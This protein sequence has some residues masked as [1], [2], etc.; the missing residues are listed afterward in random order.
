MYIPARGHNVHSPRKK[1]TPPEGN[2]QERAPEIA[3]CS[4]G[5]G[6]R[7][8]RQLTAHACKVDTKAVPQA[9]SFTTGKAP[10]V[11]RCS[12]T[13]VAQGATEKVRIQQ[14]QQCKV[15]HAREGLDVFDGLTRRNNA[16]LAQMRTNRKHQYGRQVSQDVLAPHCSST[17]PFFLPPTICDD[18]IWQKTCV[19]RYWVRLRTS[20]ACS[21]ANVALAIVPRG[22]ESVVSARN[23]RGSPPGRWADG[24]KRNGFFGS[25]APSQNESPLHAVVGRRERGGVKRER[26][27]ITTAN[28]CK[29]VQLVAA[30]DRLQQFAV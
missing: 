16:A 28:T 7:T 23:G 6:K 26:P 1:S 29:K 22:G 9:G 2:A 25:V 15:G 12:P 27:T 4:L 10:R 14:I 18:C 8:R 30:P 11:R 3:S 19:W 13:Q 17:K 20:C 5:A 24:G 21:S